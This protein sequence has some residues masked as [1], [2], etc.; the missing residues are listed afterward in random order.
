[1]IFRIKHFW[2]L[3]IVVA[4]VGLAASWSLGA[5]ENMAG[6]KFSLQILVALGVGGALGALTINAILHESFKRIIGRKYLVSFQVYGDSVLDGMGWPAYIAGGLMA[7]AAEEPIFRGLLLPMIQDAS[8]SAVVAILGAAL[9]FAICHWM[10]TRYLPFWF[11]AMWEGVLF[12]IITVY[13]G[14][15]IPAMIAH[16]LHD[17]IAYR[18]FQT[19]LRDS[20]PLS[21]QSDDAPKTSAP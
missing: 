6:D 16:F 8:G 17:V 19:L 12:G 1:V 14:S 13:A 7:G 15:I 10:K 11:W 3:A 21:L 2:P 20:P 5:W 9:V 4:V 18:V